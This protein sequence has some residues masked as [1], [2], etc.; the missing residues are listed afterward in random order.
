MS[1]FLVGGG[2]D[3]DLGEVYDEFVAEAR[4]HA[5]RQGQEGGRVAVVVAGPARVSGDHADSLASLVSDR[6]PQAELLPIHLTGPGTC[7]PAGQKQDVDA[8]AGGPSGESGEAAGPVPAWQ[9]DPGFTLPDGLDA[10]DGIVVGGGPVPSYI[11]G[12]GPAAESLSRLVRGGAPWL[13]FSAGAMVTSVAAIQGGWR[14]AGRQIAPRDAAEG[15]EELSIAEGLGLV[16]V[17]SCA[18]NDAL[19]ADGL[20]ISA[21]DAGLLRSAVAIDEGTCL[22]IQQ[23]SGRATPM[24]RGLVRWFTRDRDA[25][26]VRAEHSA[27]KEQPPAPTPPRFEGLARVAAAARAAHEKEATHDERSGSGKQEGTGTQGSTGNGKQTGRAEPA[28][29]PAAPSAGDKPSGDGETG[30]GR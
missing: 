13:G 28:S 11:A 9:E 8:S 3:D 23:G 25:V 24:G 2:V 26:S 1:F 27:T 16:S 15:F 22:R 5:G 29:S 17:T 19:S 18:H 7:P 21:V 4:S 10:L 14:L 12:L 20:L 6:W 30:S